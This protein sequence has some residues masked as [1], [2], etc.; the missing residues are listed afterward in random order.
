MIRGDFFAPPASDA[1]EAGP[2]PGVHNPPAVVD[3]PGAGDEPGVQI[4][5]LVADTP[6]VPLAVVILGPYSASTACNAR[7]SSSTCDGSSG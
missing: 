5:P 3:P 4:P 6:S 1:P 2:D 7:L